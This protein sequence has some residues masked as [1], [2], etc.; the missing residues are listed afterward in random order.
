[1]RGNIQ[2]KPAK[3]FVCCLLPG[4]STLLLLSPAALAE[5]RIGLAAPLSGPDAV[6]GAELR[7]GAEQAVAD[8]NAAGGVRGQK[9]SSSPPTI[10]VS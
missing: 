4:L 2:G 9:L 3:A 7:N 5:V 6:F 1:M 10:A 8:I